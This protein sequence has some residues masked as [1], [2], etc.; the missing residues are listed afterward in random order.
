M[1]TPPEPDGGRRQLPRQSPAGLAT[2]PG[3]P[4]LRRWSERIARDAFRYYPTLTLVR[5][6]VEEHLHDPAAI[7]MKE[8]A[9]VVSYDYRYFSRY[10]KDKVG[11]GFPEWLRLMQVDRAAHLLAHSHVSVE[12]V[13]HDAGFRSVRTLQRAFKRFCGLTPAEFRSNGPHVSRR[14]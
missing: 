14:P 9:R 12:Q 7:T 13:A 1:G 11:L 10:F 5:T 2:R 8:V 4:I 3:P 6:Y